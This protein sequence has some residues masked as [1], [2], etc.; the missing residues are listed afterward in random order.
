M[1][2][3]SQKGISLFLA[4]VI[5]AVI[6][7]MVLGLGT[8]LI[9]QLKMMR[10]MGNSVVALYAADTGVEEALKMYF[11]G[12]D[13]QDYYPY[14]GGLD[15]NAEYEVSVVCCDPSGPNCVW[16]PITKPCDVID[17]APDSNWPQIDLN[18]MATKYCIRS[19]GEYEDTKRAIEAK[20]FP[21]P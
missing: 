5:L 9:G 21:I 15:N 19:V 18:C 16:D 2:K 20:I 12:E 6:L 7:A 11:N 1:F 10:G 8:I 3:C 4:I 13:L 14:R 17:T